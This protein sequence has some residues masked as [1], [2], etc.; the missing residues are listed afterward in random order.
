MNM[1]N[2]EI[3]NPLGDL[4]TIIN[5]TDLSINSVSYS[6]KQTCSYNVMGKEIEVSG[7]ICPMVAM[8]V[9]SINVL[10]KRFYDQVKKQHVKLPKE[11]VDY[12]DNNIVAWERNKKL[13]IITNNETDNI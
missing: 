10:G 1:E 5:T 6:I 7:T 2:T 8:Y 4:N 9:A 13:N 3:N 11:I 12:V